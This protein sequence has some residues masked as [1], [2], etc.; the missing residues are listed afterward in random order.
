[1]NGGMRKNNLKII[2]FGDLE[3]QKTLKYT[4]YISK[5]SHFQISKLVL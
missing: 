5:L 1:M 2:Q 3:M 4:N